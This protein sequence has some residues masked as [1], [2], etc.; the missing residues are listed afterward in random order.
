M[1]ETKMK[2]LLAVLILA[3]SLISMVSCGGKVYEADAKE[4][5]SNGLTITLTE[6]F[7]EKEQAGYTVCYDSKSVAVIV[8]KESFSLQAGI[9]DWTL[10]HYADL[11]KS[12]NSTH[13]PSN[14]TKVGN[15]MVME[16]TFF[17]PNTNITYHYY[18]C[19][20]KGS[21]AFWMVQFACDVND[22]DEY[23]PYMIE[24]ADSVR[25]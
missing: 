11:I 13:S 3:A 7:V 18:T 8:L 14:P 9:K 17:N 6:A 25:V 23:K 15:H 22:I 1:E 20:Y 5:T 19:M 4:F 16:Y 24:W 12:S 10:E 2:K 21:D